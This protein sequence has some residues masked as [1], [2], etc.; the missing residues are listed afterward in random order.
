MLHPET[1]IKFKEEGIVDQYQDYRRET[2]VTIMK[3]GKL[4][5]K[6]V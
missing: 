1:S 3:Q 6:K 4:S 2:N 5:K